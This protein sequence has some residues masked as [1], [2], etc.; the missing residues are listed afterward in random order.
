MEVKIVHQKR[1][2]AFYYNSRNYIW[3]DSN[4]KKLTF[5]I[6]INGYDTSYL[7]RY[8]EYTDLYYIKDRSVI[9]ICGITR[10]KDG[11]HYISTY[12]KAIGFGAIV[13]KYAIEQHFKND[14]ILYSVCENVNVESVQLLSSLGFKVYKK[15]K[16]V[17]TY[18]L[19][20]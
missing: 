18:F 11:K 3:Y 9:S 4:N 15:D 19:S 1:K 20:K 6:E 2:D 17:S 16:I 7:F 13:A 14:D 5:P 10:Y 12:T 8:G